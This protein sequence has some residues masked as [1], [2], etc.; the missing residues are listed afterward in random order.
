MAVPEQASDRVPFLLEGRSFT[1][2]TAFVAAGPRVQPG[3]PTVTADN[4]RHPAVPG[5][6]AERRMKQALRVGTA[7][8]LNLCSNNPGGGLDPI[9]NFMDCTDDAGMNTCS[10]GPEDRMDASRT[11][12]RL[13]R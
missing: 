3:G 8:T 13:D 12:C 9:T 5:T 6:T 11:T 2:Q 10:A 7:A 1:S 4:T